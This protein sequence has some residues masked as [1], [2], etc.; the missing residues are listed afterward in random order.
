MFPLKMLIFYRINVL[1]K[2]SLMYILPSDAEG[3]LH[4][5]PLQQ[6]ALSVLRAQEFDSYFRNMDQPGMMS[7]HGQKTKLLWKPKNTNA[8]KK[9]RQF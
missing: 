9:P 4:R 6:W 3:Y 2:R 1:V 5:L 7:L 8:K